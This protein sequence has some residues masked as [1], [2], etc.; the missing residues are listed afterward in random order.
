MENPSKSPNKYSYKVTN[1]KS[2]NDSLKKRGKVSCWLSAKLLSIWKEVDVRNISVSEQI[3]PDVI[4]EFCLTIKHLYHLPLRQTTGFVEDLLSSQGYK[5]YCVP[6]YSTLSRRAKNL[7]VSYSESLKHKEDVHLMVDS[8]GIKVYGQGE[9]MVKKH[10]VSK[11]RTWL[12]LHLGIDA[13]TQEIV[14][15]SLTNNDI[16]DADAAKSIL[17]EHQPFLASFRGDGAYDKFHFR[18]VL[19]NKVEQKIPPPCNAVVHLGSSHSPPPAYLLQRNQAVKRIE[20]IGR[21]EWKEEIGYHRRS[22][23][24][25]AMFRYKIIF[26]DKSSARTDDNQATEAKIKCKIL[27]S[28]T[29]M[30]MPKTVRVFKN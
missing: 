20:E 30:G 1:W 13:D 10:G 24:E 29:N 27:N 15:M 19:G 9:W 12:K 18:K 22:L 25:T 4:I 2:Y 7:P 6:D 8:T 11:H 21:K 5:E 28:F 23:A 3:Y 14:A 16:A 17:E 26:G